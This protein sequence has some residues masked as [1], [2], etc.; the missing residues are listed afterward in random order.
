MGTIALLLLSALLVLPG[1][2]TMRYSY[3]NW[4]ASHPAEGGSAS[5]NRPIPHRNEVDNLRLPDSSDPLVANTDYA[6]E[7]YSRT[8][9]QDP[10]KLPV[11]E[12][13]VL[14][15]FAGEPID[16]A[17]RRPLACLPRDLYRAPWLWL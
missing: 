17:L 5:S 13:T 9:G 12:K 16:A 15:R 14:F 2:K 7:E 4:H 1:R 8:T 3:A 6:A 10:L 11:C